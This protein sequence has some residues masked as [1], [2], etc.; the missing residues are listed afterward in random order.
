MRANEALLQLANTYKISY[1]SRWWLK[2]LHYLKGA[3]SVVLAH[4]CRDWGGICERLHERM[5]Y[6][7]VIAAPILQIC[8]RTRCHADSVIH[9]QNLLS[10]RLL[11]GSLRHHLNRILGNSMHRSLSDYTV[12]RWFWCY[13]PH[14]L[15]Q[16]TV[17]WR[18]H[19]KYQILLSS[20]IFLAIINFF[21]LS[22]SPTFR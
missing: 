2:D 20:L 4:W 12:H 5:V 8:F 6:A 19:W 18:R 11:N 14:L 15:S 9:R 10:N 3:I 22:N 17:M 1:G 13:S 21:N 16:P 7:H